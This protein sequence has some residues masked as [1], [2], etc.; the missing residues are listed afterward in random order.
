MTEKNPR[1]PSLDSLMKGISLIDK[2]F[3]VGSDGFIAL[4]DVM[5]SDES[6]EQAA[7]I[8]YGKGTRKKNETRGLL[9]YLKR[10]QHTSPFEQAELQ[11]HVRVP[12]DTW[13]QWIRHRTASVN[14]YST[15]YS[16]A[17]NARDQTP[18]DKWRLQSSNNKQGSVGYLSEWSDDI[19]D[20][21]YPILDVGDSDPNWYEKATPGEILSLEE[22]KL[23]KKGQEVYQQRVNMGVAREQARK[24][25]PLSTYT[26]AFWKCD[27]HNLMHFCMLRCDSHAQLEIREY[28]NIIAGIMKEQ[29][30][31]S[32]EAWYDYQLQSVNFTRLDRLLLNFIYRESGYIQPIDEKITEYADNIGMSKREIDEFWSKIEPPEEADFNLDTLPLY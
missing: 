8:S 23:H 1:D 18:S 16:E 4:K 32:F 28:A 20:H 21:S 22:A 15:R 6:I 24:D 12:M 10:N 11:F 5:G 3:A 7:R 9:R 27:L 26:E 2:Y 29:F 31:L 25:L 30:P 19:L 17:I 13:R 14:E